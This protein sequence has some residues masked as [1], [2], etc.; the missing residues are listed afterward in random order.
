AT[1]IG[2]PVILKASGGGGGRGM[3]VVRDETQVQRAFESATA[4]AA[5]AFKNPDI[6]LEKYLEEPRHIEFQALADM[7]GGVWTLGERECSLQRRH[8]KV[9][10]EAP[11][12]AMTPEKRQSMGEVIRKAVL[13]TGYTSL[14]TL[15]F[16]MDEKNNLYFLEM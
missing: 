4:E 10:E 1:R 7:H 14:G 12:P 2:F 15:E 8:Q 6:Y 13:E 5:A 11:S 3:R 16:L 9:M